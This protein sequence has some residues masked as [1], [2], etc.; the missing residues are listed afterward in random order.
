MSLLATTIVTDRQITT[1]TGQVPMRKTTSHRTTTA[2]G[3]QTTTPTDRLITIHTAQGAITTD[4]RA[5]T[6]MDRQT[7]TMMGR[8]TTI[9]TAQGATTT[10]DRRAMT[11]MD[12]Q[13]TTITDR[14]M[15][16]MAQVTLLVTITIHTAV[17]IR[18]AKLISINQPVET[19]MDLVTNKTRIGSTRV[20]VLRHRRQDS[21]WWV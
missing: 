19:A 20:S 4:R 18:P 1:H 12:R 21:I 7:T 15:T 6:T 5:M 2:M 16:H 17:V 11:T 9:H 8:Q 10:T 3:R 13:T 14:Q